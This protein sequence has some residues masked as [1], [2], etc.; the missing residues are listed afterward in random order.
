MGEGEGEFYKLVIVFVYGFGETRVM[1]YSVRGEGA[2]LVMAQQTFGVL[3]LITIFALRVHL[4]YFHFRLKLSWLS[5][6]DFY[7][8]ECLD[9]Q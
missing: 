9:K 8:A 6:W 3:K 4:S 1:T 5:S 7:F 2:A